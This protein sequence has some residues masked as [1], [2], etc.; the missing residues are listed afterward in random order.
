M[1]TTSLKVLLYSAF[2]K[3]SLGGIAAW[4]STYLSESERHG[5]VCTLVNCASTDARAENPEAKISICNEIIRTINIFR[6]LRQALKS[7]ID[8]AHINTSCGPLGII[9]DC[10]AV[11]I[12]KNRNVK[13][14]VHFHCDIPFWIHNRIGKFCLK[15]M[16]ENADQI[17]VLCHN[18][19]KYL[20]D[21]F[22]LSSI[23]IPNFVPSE[24]IVSAHKVK[25]EL[26]DVIYVGGVQPEKGCYE[27]F[28]TAEF[29]P[30][31][32]FR[33]VG[34][35][36]ED[37]KSVTV[38]DNVQLMGGMQHDKV[39]ELMD[40]ADLF[41][42]PSHSEGFSLA[43]AEAMSRGLPVIA[44]DVGANFDMIENHGGL[45]VP[46]RDVQGIIDAIKQL[47][48]VRLRNSM[49]CW[50]I[51]KVQEHYIAKEVVEKIKNCYIQILS[52]EQ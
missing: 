49:S 24:N 23:M 45:I 19:A 37:I 35:L 48:D 1:N 21:S 31:I 50:N 11:K 2:P 5:L 52:R 44:T 42:F 14:V 25:G 40:Q 29:F 8:I 17:F 41:I 10:I 4:T 7:E 43:L 33:L 26:T 20:Q 36:N 46:V 51:K 28:R 15:R 22:D 18:S 6:S 47:E 39:L 3:N 9:R 13:A 34:Q 16:C 32:H 27:L 12:V 38:P 30:D